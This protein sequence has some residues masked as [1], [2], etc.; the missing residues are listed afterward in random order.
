MAHKFNIKSKSKLD[1]EWRRENLQSEATLLS[2]GLTPED[3]MAD[4][5]CGIGYFTIPAAQ[6]VNNQVFALDTSEEMLEEVNQRMVAA[7]LANVTTLK[8]DE[9]DL[10]IPIESVSFA[11]LALVLH[12]IDDKKRMITEIHRILKPE[13]RIAVIEW[14]KEDTEMGPPC[15]HRIGKEDVDALF[16]AEKFERIDSKKIATVFYGSIFRVKA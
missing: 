11:L 4:I 10:K 3:S 15:A 2:L 5:G 12:E 9:Y 14:I 16:T 6:I 13:G 1:N 7:G 8:T